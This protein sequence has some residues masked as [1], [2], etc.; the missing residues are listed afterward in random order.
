MRIVVGYEARETKDA[1]IITLGALK[2]G[3]DAIPVQVWRLGLSE[4]VGFA[5]DFERS[6]MGEISFEIVI[7][8]DHD[9]DIIK[10]RTPLMYVTDVKGDLDEDTEMVI[11]YH[12]ATIKELLFGVTPNAWGETF[13]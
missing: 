9:S 3:G 4:T 6:E 5:R 8:D 12:E 1:R 10:G 7:D 2:P 11:V 13:D